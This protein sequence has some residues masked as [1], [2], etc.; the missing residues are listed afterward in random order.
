LGV[1]PAYIIRVLSRG[2]EKEEKLIPEG[3]EKE[4]RG[5]DGK[6]G[7]FGG[8]LRKKRG[9]GSRGDVM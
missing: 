5:K 3:K 4:N 9:E 7:V 2:Q 6:K 1:V 8:F